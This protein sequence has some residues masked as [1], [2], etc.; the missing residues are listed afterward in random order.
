MVIK[1]LEGR[2]QGARPSSVG[3]IGFGASPRGATC[4]PGH[5]GFSQ[6][7]EVASSLWSE[8]TLTSIR[9]G[10]ACSATGMATVNTPPS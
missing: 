5:K 3:R 8:P 6:T 10:F 2:P 1:G 7:A 9:R 4:S